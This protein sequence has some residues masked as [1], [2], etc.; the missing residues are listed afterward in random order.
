MQQINQIFPR[1]VMWR[2]PQHFG[3]TLCRCDD[4]LNNNYVCCKQIIGHLSLWEVFH[5]HADV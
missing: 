2:G 1:N 4:Q 3:H 5:K